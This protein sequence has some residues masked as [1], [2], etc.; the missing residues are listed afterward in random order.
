MRRPVS[1]LPVLLLSALL[2]GACSDI[3][4]RDVRNFA[5]RARLDIPDSAVATGYQEF[6]SDSGMV[7]LR[8]ELPADDLAAFLAGSDLADDL[9]N[10]MDP[11]PA[12]ASFSGLLEAHPKKF[13][14]GQKDLGGGYFLNVLI[15]EDEPT[16]V[17]YLMW[18]GT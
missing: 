8:L 18:F 15:D 2:V 5:E 10:T 16:R 6:V 1:A 12:L 13:R 9:T 17:A 4:S 7:Y 11:G 3:S 14:E